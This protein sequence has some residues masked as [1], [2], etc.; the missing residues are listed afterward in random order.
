MKD[1]KNPYEA[2]YANLGNSYVKPSK[3]Y[4]HLSFWIA[5]ISLIL[6]FSISTIINRGYV[7]VEQYIA[8]AWFNT[9]T[10]IVYSFLA[11]GLIFFFFYFFALGRYMGKLGRSGIAWGGL[12][13]ILSPIGRK[14]T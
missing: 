11:I 1:F 5:H 3:K 12:A 9:L 10:I 6:F 4:V 13:F 14:R 7:E 2:P 8:S